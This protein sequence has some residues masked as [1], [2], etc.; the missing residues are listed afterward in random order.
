MRAG[1]L[2]TVDRDLAES[3]YAEHSKK[4]GSSAS[5]STSS[6]RRRRLRS[7]SRARAAISGEIVR[8]TMGAT[9]PADS[10]PGTGSA[11]TSRSRCGRQP[12]PRLRF[13]GIRGARDRAL[14]R[15]WPGLGP[16]L[17][18]LVPGAALQS[19]APRGVLSRVRSLW[20][21]TLPA[22][23]RC[24]LFAGAE[25]EP[26]RRWPRLTHSGTARTGTGQSDGVPA[27]ER[28]VHRAARAAL[29]HVAS[30]PSG[31]ARRA[32]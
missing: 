13:A 4:P 14:V 30:F 28:R 19:V 6:P 32:R 22:S 5:W 20:L 18:H 26:R 29:G 24:L 21:R 10:T 23:L 1:K 27:A 17:S 3:H 2:L 31:R 11:A 12:R 7:S 8:S 9:N 16:P 25:H 15:R